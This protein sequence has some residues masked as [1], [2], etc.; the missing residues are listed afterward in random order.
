MWICD[1]T[2]SL[3][4]PVQ[5]PRGGCS[6]TE[7]KER[8]CLVEWLI[9]LLRQLDRLGIVIQAEFEA[10]V[11]DINTARRHLGTHLQ[12]GVLLPVSDRQRVV[13]RC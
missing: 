9:N 1:P 11:G 8:V 13:E 3:E 7:V 12:P 5:I 6:R 4:R 2:Q 10:E